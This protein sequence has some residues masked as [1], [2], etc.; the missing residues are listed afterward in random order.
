MLTI[1]FN[2]NRHIFIDTTKQLHVFFHTTTATAISSSSFLGCRSVVFAKVSSLYVSSFTAGVAAWHSIRRLL[3]SMKQGMSMSGLEP[4]T[5]INGQ[6]RLL[7]RLLRVSVQ[8]RAS[9]WLPLAT[10]TTRS[11]RLFSSCSHPRSFLFFPA[12]L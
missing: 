7:T 12:Y 8:N 2:A 3:P 5:E 11:I 10:N 9:E 1:S 4:V 6:N